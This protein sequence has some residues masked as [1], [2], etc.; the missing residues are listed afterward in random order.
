MTV[1]STQRVYFRQ[2]DKKWAAQI[3]TAKDRIAA[4]GRQLDESLAD[5]TLP[6]MMDRGPV[7][8]V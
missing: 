4:A 6:T 7:S 1:P 8:M 2:I 5:R 3:Q